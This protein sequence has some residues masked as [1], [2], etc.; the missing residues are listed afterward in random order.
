M[1]LTGS[2][3]IAADRKVVWA[4]LTDA[5]MLQASIPGCSKM[6]GS[7]SDGFEAVVTQKIGPVTATFKGLVT[8]SDIVEAQ[9]YRISGNG[10]GGPA[11]YA[12]GA[13]QVT[14]ED[15]DGGTLLRYDVNA[16]VGGKLA[17]LGSRLIDGVAKKLADQFF[18]KFQTTVEGV[19]VEAA[20]DSPQA[21]QSGIVG[22]ILQWLKG[23]FGQK[24]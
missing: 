2:R 22:K 16:Q 5:K 19:S 11:G 4:A 6:S 13:A 24:Q 8:L 7:V 10:K 12:K 23:L 20:S 18:E 9:C 3:I 1:E 15:A 17:S 21:G 14:L